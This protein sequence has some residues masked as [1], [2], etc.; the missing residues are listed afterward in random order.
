MTETQENREKST[1]D[2]DELRDLLRQLSVDQIRFVAARQ[3]CSS[4]AEAA[5]QI[6]VKPNTVYGWPETVKRAAKLMQFDGVIA[7]AEVLRQHVVDAAMVKI[8]GLTL[9]D[10]RLRQSVATEILDRVLGKAIETVDVQSKGEKVGST[11]DD[12]AEALAIIQRSGDGAAG[13]G[14][15]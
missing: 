14:D 4:D 5:N 13:G 10:D 3:H 15:H 8:D 11:R 6:G 2:P 12:I 9:D 1:I 7:A